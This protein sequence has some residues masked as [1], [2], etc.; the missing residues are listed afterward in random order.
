MNRRNSLVGVLLALLLLG[1]WACDRPREAVFSGDSITIAT[2]NI[3]WLGD[4]TRDRFDRE[5]HDY[6]LIAAS[7]R[8]CGAD[9]LGIQEVENAAALERLMP[10]LPGFAYLIS[11]G[12]RQ[13]RLAVLYRESIDVQFVEEL[14]EIAITPGLRPGLVVSCQA[15]SFDALILLVHYKSSSRWDSTPALRKRSYELRER[16]AALTSDWVENALQ[17]REQDIIVMGDFND[18]PVDDN[19]PTLIPLLANPAIDFITGD[20]ISCKNKRWKAIDHIVLSKSSQKRLIDGSV[21]MINLFYQ[22]G[23]KTA[24]RISDHCPVIARLNVA[25]PDND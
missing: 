11:K 21:G 16:Q 24:A 2:F 23:R 8:E 12:G 25:L 10:Y 7:I 20:L 5:E 9:I 3:A 14:D 1:L 6:E 19:S 17:G 13:Q 18:S 22:H 4:G 15:V